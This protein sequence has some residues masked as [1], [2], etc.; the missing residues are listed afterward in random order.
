MAGG[1]T[2]DRS[3][4]EGGVM[5]MSIPAAVPVATHTQI[6]A[7][8]PAKDKVDIFKSLLATGF[9]RS[10]DSGANFWRISFSCTFTYVD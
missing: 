6:N 8:T 1:I 4:G 10:N 2:G 3:H 5:Y 9:T 7:H